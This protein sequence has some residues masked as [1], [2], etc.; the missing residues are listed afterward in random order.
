MLVYMMNSSTNSTSSVS[1]RRGESGPVPKPAPG[2]TLTRWVYQHQ[3]PLIIPNVNEVNRFS[4]A[5]QML[6]LRLKSMAAT[7]WV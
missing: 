2:E 3:Q 5:V 1:T 4:R 6:K 7:H